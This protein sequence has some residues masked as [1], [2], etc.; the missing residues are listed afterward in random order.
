[1]SVGAKRKA[2]ARK[3]SFTP[4]FLWDSVS[5]GWCSLY[6]MGIHG[7]VVKV[8]VPAYLLVQDDTEV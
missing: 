8:I 3:S 6:I 2:G 5:A 4:S 1:M 7:T